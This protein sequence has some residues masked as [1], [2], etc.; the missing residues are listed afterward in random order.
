MIRFKQKRKGKLKE[1]KKAINV[2]AVKNT[3]TSN[4]FKRN[5]YKLKLYRLN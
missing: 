4:S 5:K 1:M 3:H 2:V